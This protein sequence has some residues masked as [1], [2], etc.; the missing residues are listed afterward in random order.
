MRCF[1]IE[2]VRE[3][4]RCGGRTPHSRRRVAPLLV[5]AALLA[6][7]AL[8]LAFLGAAGVVAA[9]LF[10][11]AGAFL[12]LLDRRSGWHL[13]CERCRGKWLAS[14][15]LRWSDLRDTAFS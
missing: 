7:L 4:E 3:C 9:L 2:S 13:A 12:V 6:A 1:A 15:R 10:G 8:R 11:A 14:R 5:A